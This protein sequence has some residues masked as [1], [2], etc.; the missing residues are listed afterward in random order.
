MILPPFLRFFLCKNLAP[1]HFLQFFSS[2]FKYSLSN[3]PS[4]HPYN[5][6]AMNLPSIS[7]CSSSTLLLSLPY[8]FS[9]LSTAS[10]AFFRFASLSHKSSSAIYPFH[11]TKYSHFPYFLLL[12][13]ILSTSY[14]SSP[15]IT[16]RRAGCFFCP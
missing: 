7:L 10:L 13:I 9:Y 15:S 1:F 5:N 12:F 14:S 4:S 6:F 16:T 8:S 3:F 2:F 11:L